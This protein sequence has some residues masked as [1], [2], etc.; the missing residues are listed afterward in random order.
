MQTS[1]RDCRNEPAKLTG[2]PSLPPA[3]R[4][5][6]R[7]GRGALGAASKKEAP[8]PGLKKEN[9]PNNN[10]AVL[11]VVRRFTLDH[12]PRRYENEPG[13]VLLK[14]RLQPEHCPTC[15]LPPRAPRVAER[16]SCRR[17]HNAPT[18]SIAFALTRPV[19]QDSLH[20]VWPR[21]GSCSSGPGTPTML[22]TLHSG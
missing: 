12:P 7:G 14:C 10:L 18:R 16:S 13:S 2:R 15:L 9:A 8:L 11:L 20:S 5:H 19:N 22:F 4:R 3:A 21:P 17:P 1:N 6:A